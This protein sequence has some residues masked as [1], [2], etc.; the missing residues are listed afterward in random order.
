[1]LVPGSQ[2]RHWNSHRPLACGAILKKCWCHDMGCDDGWYTV[3]VSRLCLGHLQTVFVFS[4][5]S[6]LGA[7]VHLGGCTQHA[8]EELQA[9]LRTQASIYVVPTPT[10]CLVSVCLLLCGRQLFHP[11]AALAASLGSAAK[12]DEV[13]CHGSWHPLSLITFLYCLSRAN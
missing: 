4:M 11:E 8:S 5:L 9:Y 7:I 6:F 2:H 13:P 1:M 10:S 12:L 3:P